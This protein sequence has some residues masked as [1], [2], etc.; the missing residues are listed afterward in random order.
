MSKIV[1][2]Q[3][4]NEIEPVDQYC[5]SCGALNNLAQ[6]SNIAEKP[7]KPQQF[8][9]MNELVEYLGTV[10]QRLQALEVENRWLRATV[11][12]QT[13]NVDGN[14]ISKYVS[15]ALPQ[16]NL[17]SP[18]F[19]KRAFAVWGH[20]FVSNLIIGIIIGIIYVCLVMVLLGSIIH[21][22]K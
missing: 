20:F 15:R 11:P 16:T 13:N 7:N 4:G 12:S 18:S 17:F 9:S 10:E 1:C 5:P 3:C 8:K 22:S 6:V 2:L 19:L 14:L 21:I